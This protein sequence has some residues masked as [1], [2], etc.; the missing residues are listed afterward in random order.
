MLV[1]LTFYLLI[2]NYQTFIQCPVSVIFELNKILETVTT[3]C[4][5]LRLKCTKIRCPL[6]LRPQ[7]PL[8]EITAL[9]QGPDRLTAF[10]GSY[11]QG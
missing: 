7:T 11:F 9:P 8:R 5:I 6:E 1:P 10:K 4:Q 3:R 2:C